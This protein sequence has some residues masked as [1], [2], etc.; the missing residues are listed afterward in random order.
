M[1]GFVLFCFELAQVTDVT[2]DY[3]YGLISELRA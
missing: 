1:L 3:K 2:P